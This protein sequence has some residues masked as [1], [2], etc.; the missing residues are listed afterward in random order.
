[1]SFVKSRGLNLVKKSQLKYEKKPEL[2]D[3]K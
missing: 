3:K 1:M 2:K